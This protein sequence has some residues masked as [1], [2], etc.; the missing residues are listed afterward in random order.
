MT[1]LEALPLLAYAAAIAAILAVALG[2]DAL[3]LQAAQSQGPGAGKQQVGQLVEQWRVDGGGTRSVV[4][5]GLQPQHVWRRGRAAGGGGGAGVP[6]ACP[7][8][9]LTSSVVF[10]GSREM[11][12][13]PSSLQFSTRTGPDHCRGDKHGAWQPN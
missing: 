4:Q 3:A 6:P 9:L 1:L 7:A 11:R 8:H 13:S 2:R 10:C 5:A 12:L